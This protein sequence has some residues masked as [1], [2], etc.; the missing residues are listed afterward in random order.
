MVG[1]SES[2]SLGWIRRFMFQ[3]NWSSTPCPTRLSSEMFSWRPRRPTFNTVGSRDRGCQCSV[4]RGS[5]CNIK[6]TFLKNPVIDMK[7]VNQFQSPS[8]VKMKLKRCCTWPLFSCSCCLLHCISFGSWPLTAACNAAFRWAAESQMRRVNY[9][10]RQLESSNCFL[11]R[12]HI[13]PLMVDL[14]KAT[15]GPPETMEK[16]RF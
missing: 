14:L 2:T 10:N 9:K 6:I 16:C 5:K 1:M 3:G 11:N 15:F 8:F 7:H 4:L 12:T 13:W